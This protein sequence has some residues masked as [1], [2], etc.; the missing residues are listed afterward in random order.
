MIDSDDYISNIITS[1][2]PIWVENQILYNIDILPNDVYLTSAYD[3]IKFVQHNL[4]ELDDC[5]CCTIYG[6]N[7][8]GAQ[9]CTLACFE[10]N[11]QIS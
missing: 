2:N 10:C 1:I 3:D 7:N 9:C 4:F 6:Y 5:S 8:C 11:K